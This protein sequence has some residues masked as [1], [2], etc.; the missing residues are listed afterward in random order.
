MN[1]VL[2]NKIQSIQRCV[3]RAREEYGRDPGGFEKNYTVQD[4]AILNV[5]RACEQT[6]DLANHAIRTRQ[7]GI[8]NSS[9]ES[10]RLLAQSGL[11]EPERAERLCRMVGFR[12]VAVHNY[13]RL[14]LALVRAVI[15]AGLDD[16]LAFA[17]RLRQQLGQSPP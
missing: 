1:D 12:N 9:A 14:D 7:L 2:V 8:P 6:I 3:A 10:F 17:D 4:A 16:L 15:E 13:R 5:L 11:V